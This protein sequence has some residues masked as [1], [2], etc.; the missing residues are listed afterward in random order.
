MNGKVHMQLTAEGKRLARQIV[1]GNTSIPKPRK[2]DGQWRIVI[3][4][5]PEQKKEL[6]DR[7][8]YLVKRLGFY[9]LQQSVW[10]H[11]YECEEIITLLK[12]DL[13]VGKDL[14]Y[15]VGTAIE[16]DKPLRRHFGIA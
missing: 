10:V 13:R 4:D 5:I 1:N 8:R 12:T 11:P 16:F 9:K 2:W 6:R 3:F 14:L 7:V 15:I